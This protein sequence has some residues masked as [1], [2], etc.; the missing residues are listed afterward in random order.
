MGRYQVQ[1]S[2]IKIPEWMPKITQPESHQIIP[3][4][5]SEGRGIMSTVDDKKITVD[6]IQPTTAEKPVGKRGRKFQT[7]PTDFI[8]ELSGEG[9]GS[10]AI[11]AALARSG[12]QVS[13]KTIQRQLAGARG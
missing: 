10:K 9:L 5:S 13:Y 2:H 12:Y 11:A 6:I 7:L 3:H 1:G 4:V 8:Q